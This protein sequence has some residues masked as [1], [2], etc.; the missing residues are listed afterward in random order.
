M[1]R[2][3]H[4]IIECTLRCELFLHLL[5]I[6]NPVK[7]KFWYFLSVYIVNSTHLHAANCIVFFNIE[8]QINSFLKFIKSHCKKWK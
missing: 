4:L 1:V 3:L 6:L 8:F 2:R 7:L 5:L